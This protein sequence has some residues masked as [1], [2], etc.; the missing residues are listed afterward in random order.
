MFTPRTVSRRTAVLTAGLATATGL[1]L[2][3]PSSASADPPRLNVDPCAQELARAAEWPGD[4]SDGT[5]FY[6]DGFDRYLSRQPACNPG[7]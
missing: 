6:S 7:N 2:F 5:R 3:G 1:V 4:D